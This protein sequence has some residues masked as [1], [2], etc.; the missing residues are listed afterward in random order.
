MLIRFIMNVELVAH[1]TDGNEEEFVRPVNTMMTVD[2]VSATN[3]LQYLDIVLKDGAKLNGV[4]KDAFTILSGE[5]TPYT[6]PVK[7]SRSKKS[8]KNN[9]ED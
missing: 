7:K 5:I 2:Q 3:E 1:T 4:N 9:S 6:P 8:S